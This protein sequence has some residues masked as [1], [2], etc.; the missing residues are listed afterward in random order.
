MKIKIHILIASQYHICMMWYIY[1]YIYLNTFLFF[2]YRKFLE[3]EF[4]GKG[5]A[6]CKVFYIYWQPRDLSHMRLPVF[7]HWDECEWILNEWLSWSRKL[8]LVKWKQYKINVRGV[9]CRDH[10]HLP[11]GQGLS[12]IL[13]TAPPSCAFFLSFLKSYLFI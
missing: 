11:R 3:V 13:L 4:W 5:C 6:I 1:I 9:G 10:P 7:S 12:L 2:P 8:S